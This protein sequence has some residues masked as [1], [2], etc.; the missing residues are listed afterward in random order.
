MDIFTAIIIFNV[1][2]LTIWMIFL[3]N[4]RVNLKRQ[5]A[6]KRF[7]IRLIQAALKL[8]S[9]EEAA[10]ALHI[11]VEEFKAQCEKRYVD[12]PEIRK[13]KEDLIKKRK[14]EEEKR[15]IAEEEQWRAEQDRIVNERRAALEDDTKRRMERL[16]KFGFK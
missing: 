14:N 6:Y 16:K 2:A 7:L 11:T 1:A 9:S 8:N 3:I 13:E 12:T 15:I 4:A 5:I 10:A